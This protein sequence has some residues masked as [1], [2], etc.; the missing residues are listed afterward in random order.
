RRH[1][2]VAGG[3]APATDATDGSPCRHVPPRPEARW[4]MTRGLRAALRVWSRANAMN[5]DDY[6][7]D[8]LRGV[9]RSVKTIALAGARPHWNRPSY[10]VI[11][12]LQAK[13]Y[14][15]IPVNPPATGQE[16]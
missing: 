16:I 1:A 12:H 3:S 7:D 5:H 9:L 6:A 8:H 4:N 15:V 13:G 11:K 14:R 10:I 2:A